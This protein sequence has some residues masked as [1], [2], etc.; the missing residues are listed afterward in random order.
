MKFIFCFFGIHNWSIESMSMEAYA[1]TF[2][3]C[4][5]CGKMKYFK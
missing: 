2:H 3:Y 4:E 1:K 5:H